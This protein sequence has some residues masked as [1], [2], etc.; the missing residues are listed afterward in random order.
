M[1]P[2]VCAANI[3]RQEGPA[4]LMKGWTALLVRDIPFNTIFFGSYNT[5][6]SAM[7]DSHAELST[8]NDGGR[9]AMAAPALKI[10]AAAGE[11]GA[12]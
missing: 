12:P 5:L 1:S 9:L 8:F 4:G 6:C 3:C 10:G 11:R 2:L 7:A